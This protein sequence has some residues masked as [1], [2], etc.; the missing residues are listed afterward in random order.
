MPYD[1]GLARRLR[2]RLD[3]AARIRETRMFGGSSSLPMAGWWS[4]SSGTG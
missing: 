1:E 4:G 2:E 3:G